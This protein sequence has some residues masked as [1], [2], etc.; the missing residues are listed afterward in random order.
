MRMYHLLEADPFML[1]Y[2]QR[3]CARAP[4]KP[5]SRGW[6]Q[7]GVK[8]IRRGGASKPVENRPS[9]AGASRVSYTQRVVHPG[10]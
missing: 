3:G 7:C 2:I 4:R 5:V 1:S 8:D 10:L 9:R 6:C